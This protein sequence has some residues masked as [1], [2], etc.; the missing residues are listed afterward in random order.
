M[1]AL[2]SPRVRVPSRSDVLEQGSLRFQ[3]IVLHEAPHHFLDIQNK[4]L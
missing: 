3:Q 4:H 1:L 2:R